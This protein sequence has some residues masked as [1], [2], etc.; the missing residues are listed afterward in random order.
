MAKR[1]KM[2]KPENIK[3]QSGQLNSVRQKK[4]ASQRDSFLYYKAQASA[5]SPSRLPFFLL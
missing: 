1:N 2:A 4:A 3:A 5:I